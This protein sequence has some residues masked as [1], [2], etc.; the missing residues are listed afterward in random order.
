MSESTTQ[1]PPQA[2]TFCWHEVCVREPEKAKAFYTELFG[3]DTE[4]MPMPPESGVSEYTM[5]KPKNAPHVAGI[6]HMVGEQWEGVPPHWIAYIAVDDIHASTAKA[7]ELGAEIKVP[8]F[9]VGD[10]GHMSVIQ[11]PAG[12]A[13][14]MWQQGNPD[15]G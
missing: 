6:Q 10:M 8:V 1:A 14:C 7:A 13:F 2:G 11:D 9:P 4:T 3:W 12:A 5:F 15:C